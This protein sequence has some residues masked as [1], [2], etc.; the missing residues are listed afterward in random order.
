MP[1]LGVNVD[2]IATLRQAR[3]GIYPSPVLAAEI[4]EK[5][6]CDSI[7]AHLRED[8]RHIIDKDIYDLKK[9]VKT[10]F[11]LEMSINKEIVDIACHII[12][13]EATLVPEKRQELTTEGGL[14]L[15]RDFRRLDKAIM[16]LHKKGICVSLFINPDRK[17]VDL[18]KK[19]GAEMVE[20]HTGYYAHAKGKK[21]AA[22]QIDI[23]KDCTGHA[24]A[25]GL[26][27]NAGHGLDYINVG[28]IA[29]IRG[30]NELNIGHSIISCA[31]LYGLSN[32]VKKMKDLVS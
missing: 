8:R 17:S 16:R 28:R 9:S 26:T 32:A 19:L 11:N 31:V 10:R 4:S 18:S 27:A 3:R 2:H 15:K 29:D 23:I 1:K 7:V 12:P 20:F 24:L 6:G 30:I 25:L 21:E 13:D 5:A 14:D 22:R